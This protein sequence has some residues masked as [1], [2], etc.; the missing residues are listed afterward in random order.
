ML[1]RLVIL[2]VLLAALIAMGGVALRD[3][4]RAFEATHQVSAIEA[5]PEAVPALQ[6]ASTADFR[7]VAGDW[8]QIPSLNPFSFDR[9]D[10]PIL[11]TEEP[12][13]PGPKPLLFGTMALGSERM[14]MVGPGGSREYRPMKA[15][16][17]INGWTIA[18][19]QEKSILISA[20]GLTETIIMN[21]PTASIPRERGRTSAS[22]ASAP[23][24]V[25]SPAAA[26]RPAGGNNAAAASSSS[27]G[28]QPATR[29]IRTPFGDKVVPIEPNQ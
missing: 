27:G 2:N 13:P 14:A 18:E 29:V 8:T 28:G 9:S 23:V 21:D 22:P 24:Q 10:I 5:Q 3:Q 19:I 6:Q 20:D 26:P 16:E 4:W 15:G 1:K 7:Q 11:S 25:V 12:V 17:V